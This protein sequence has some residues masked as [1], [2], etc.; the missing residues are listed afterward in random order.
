MSEVLK[1]GRADIRLAKK[2]DHENSE[3]RQEQHGK[4]QAVGKKTADINLD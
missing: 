2:P 3:G 4:H 1:R